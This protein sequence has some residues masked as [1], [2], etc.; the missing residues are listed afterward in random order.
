MI[1]ILKLINFERNFRMQ[2]SQ[3]YAEIP[4]DYLSTECRIMEHWIIEIRSF[5]RESIAF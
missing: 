3:P 1:L 5:D 4:K 2:Y